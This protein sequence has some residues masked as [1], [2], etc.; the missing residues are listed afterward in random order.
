MR[1]PLALLP[2][3]LLSLTIMVYQGFGQWR[4]G[5]VLALSTAMI[6]SLLVT[7]GFVQA[8]ARKGSSYLSQGY[9][10]AAQRVVGVII[11]VALVIVIITA[12][13]FAA[14]LRWSGWLS[15]DDMGLMVVA[16]IA[17]SLLWLAAGVLALFNQSYWFGGAIAVGLGLSYL[18]LEGLVRISIPQ[19]VIMLV[20][21]IVGMAGT[22][23]VA[24]LV[25]RA[26]SSREAAA[27][28]VANQS[29]TLAPGAQLLVGLTPYFSYG[30]LYIVFILSGHIGGWLGALRTAPMPME[31]IGTIEV[32]LTVAVGGF[33]LAGGVAECTMRRFWE[34]VQV[35]QAKTVHTRPDGFG[36][37]I[38]EFFL[39]EQSDFLVAL[40]LCSFV[41]AVGVFVLV[42]LFSSS[43]MTAL[44]W[45]DKSTVVFV[46]GLVGYGLMAEGIF[47][48]MFMITLSQPWSASSAVVS[49][50]AVAVV[51]G[52][53]FSK[54]LPYQYATL[55]VVAGGL[56]LMLISRTRLWRIL[57][58][59][60]YFYYA[61][62]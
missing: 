42:Q 12:G 22:L 8:F 33:I 6:G 38:R 52:L 24:M 57:K 18:C 48:C 28:G 40:V 31:E 53:V 5:Q 56:T 14:L 9:V 3:I 21:V 55:N 29:M 35:Y 60:D 7:S 47:N 62:F 44:P 43:G 61:S 54:V 59:A 58:D 51:T 30:V 41:V 36:H 19:P 46:I 13:L 17:L 27:G 1:G 26:A 23:T 16:Y 45:S 32:G 34:R 11:G 39:K 2:I 20:A 15:P 50:I 49:G 37:M 25:V 4:P 10:R